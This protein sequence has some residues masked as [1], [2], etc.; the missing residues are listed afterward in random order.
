MNKVQVGPTKP[1]QT[2]GDRNQSSTLTNFLRVLLFMS[3]CV[4][5]AKVLLNSSMLEESIAPPE[6]STRTNERNNHNDYKRNE[7]GIVIND[8]VNVEYFM[9]YWK[10]SDSE[11]T[12]V[13]E[14][15]IRL[16]DGPQNLPGILVRY[17]NAQGGDVKKAEHMFRAML[18]YR[19]KHDVDSLVETYQVP[20]FLKK[21]YPGAILQGLDHD[22]DPV[23]M[24]RMGVTDLAGLLHEYGH[25]E[26][27]R[28]EIYKRESAVAGPWLSDWEKQAGR[29]IQRIVIIE[30]M[31]GLSA[32]L[33]SAKVGAVF[34]DTMKM[35]QLCYPD[36]AKKII[37]IR[38]PVIFRAAWS[39]AKHLFPAYI[40]EKMEFCG[41]RN[42][43]QV[44]GKYMDVDILPDC[45]NPAG[46][47]A[48]RP[49]FPESFE[50]GLIPRS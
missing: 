4:I 36:V 20:P 23:F 43:L 3:P 12:A 29:P 2:I 33:L 14:L 15:R 31:K 22:G 28:Y 49:G 45:V 44:L 25:E 18:S 27:I 50:G 26:M 41:S 48:P 39:F 30:D 42:Y 17:L 34:G 38:A 32:R 1:A 11:R 37:V 16:E 24:S 46:H 9:D 13:L 7:D 10:L 8:W 47:G 21:H 5:R 6:S 35:D 40:Q 19:E